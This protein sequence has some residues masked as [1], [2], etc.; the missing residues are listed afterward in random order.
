MSVPVNPVYRLYSWLWTGLDC[1]S[2][3]RIVGTAAGKAFTGVWIVNLVLRLYP[4]PFFSIVEVNSP[5]LAIARLK[6]RGYNHAA[7]FARPLAFV[8]YQ[9]RALRSIRVRRTQIDLDFNERPVHVEGAFCGNSTLVNGKR[10]MVIGD[11]TT[12]GARLDACSAALF[13]SGAI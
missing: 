7:L 8:K 11:G 2:P 9:P 5:S 12:N 3:L 1:V 13:E 6:E 10:I 4:N